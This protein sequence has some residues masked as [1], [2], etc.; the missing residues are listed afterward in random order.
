[1][2]MDA[3]WTNQGDD[4]Y[5]NADKSAVVPGDSTEAAYL[6][7]AKGGQISTEEAQKYGLVGSQQPAPEPPAP[8]PPAP[9]QGSAKGERGGLKVKRD[10]PENKGQG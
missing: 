6:L 8:E 9:E 1:M 3:M 7:V 5:I 2:A 10:E 4:I